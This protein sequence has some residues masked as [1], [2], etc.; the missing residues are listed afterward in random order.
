[1]K[2]KSGQIKYH[3]EIEVDVSYTASPAEP[4]TMEYPGCDAYV[5]VDSYSY[6]DELEIEAMIDDQADKIKDFCME[7]ASQPVD[8]GI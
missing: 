7:E 3:I 4:Q 2:A 6:P 1:M 5:T 8:D